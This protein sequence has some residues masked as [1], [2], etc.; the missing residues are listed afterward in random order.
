MRRLAVTQSSVR[1]NQI[2]LVQK[3]KLAMSLIIII[4]TT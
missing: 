2:E 1:N 4:T 3:K